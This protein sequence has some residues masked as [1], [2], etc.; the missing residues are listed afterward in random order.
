ML[1][2]GGD[3]E[4][5][6]Q[7]VSTSMMMMNRWWPSVLARAQKQQ[8]GDRFQVLWQLDVRNALARAGAREY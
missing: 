5:C 3:G 6:A 1:G 8:L 7:L 4:K 2:L